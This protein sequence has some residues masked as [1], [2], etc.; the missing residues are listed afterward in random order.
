MEEQELYDNLQ[1]NRCYD[2]SE[3]FTRLLHEELRLL[4]SWAAQGQWSQVANNVGFELEFWLLNQ[5]L[6]PSSQNLEF[7]HEL[8]DPHV[9]CE[10]ARAACEIN[11]PVV[12]LG[13]KA[14]S[15]LHQELM[16][17]WQR[18]QSQA[19]VHD[20]SLVLSGL[21]PTAKLDHISDEFLTPKVR[22]WQLDNNLRTLRRQPNIDINIMGIDHLQFSAKNLSLNGLTGSFQLHLQVPQRDYVRAYNASLVC[23]APVLAVSTNSPILF[24]KRLWHE[25]RVPLFEQMMAI[26]TNHEYGH[27]NNSGFGFSYLKH[28]FIELFYENAE[29][30]LHLLPETEPDKV[31][32]LFHTR[33][34]NGVVYRWSRPVV[35]FDSDGSPHL[36]I[37]FR[38]LPAGPSLVDMF[39]NAAFFYGLQHMLAQQRFPCEQQMDFNTTKA[40][41]YQAARYGIKAE[42]TWLD[43]AS[44]AC[45]DLLLK[46]LIPMA[47]EGLQDLGCAYAECEQ[48][49]EIIKE[50]TQS[51]ITGSQWQLDQLNSGYNCNE[52]AQM[53][54]KMQQF[55]RPVHTWDNHL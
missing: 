18:C 46:Q 51:G 14:I 40:N 45:Q 54:I 42:L 39:A 19:Q 36:R 35:D 10:V 1:Q 53:M 2:Q 29:S 37:E 15:T 31:A 22:Y 41:F 47:A 43:K 23:L 21:L 27:M 13:D 34:Q 8:G 33:L 48:Y 26:P 32:T 6:Q 25:T 52:I 4:A 9:V 11:S 49:L 28:S 38:A 44:Y 17:L 12:T 7:L 5:Q 24:G 3:P 30:Y 50:R 20:S 16:A 55:D